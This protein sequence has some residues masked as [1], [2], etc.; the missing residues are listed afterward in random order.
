MTTLKVFPLVYFFCLFHA[1]HYEVVRCGGRPRDL[2][3]HDET[4]LWQKPH[5]CQRKANMGHP[6]PLM[7]QTKTPAQA[8]LNGA[9]EFRC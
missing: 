7:V 2:L 3:L 4:P 8:R 9:P 6:T 5:I 1:C